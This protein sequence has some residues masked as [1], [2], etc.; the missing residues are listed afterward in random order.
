MQRGMESER[1]RMEKARIKAEQLAKTEKEV[2]NFKVDS[3]QNTSNDI[4][5]LIALG[6]HE[7]AQKMAQEVIAR[8][9]KD[10]A[11]YTWWGISLVKTKKL[12]E[13]I[14]KFEESAK[15][16]KYNPKTFLYW[17]LTLSME[18]KYE[19]A[20]QKYLHVIKLDPEN[21]NAFAYWGASLLALGHTKD[22]VER[23]KQALNVNPNNEIALDVMV[24]SYYVLSQYKEAWKVVANAR[25]RNVKIPDATLE[26]LKDAMPE[27]TS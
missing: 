1:K 3:F 8:N 17:G 16:D 14:Q 4:K 24:N 7:E 18:H 11:T 10:A 27:P 13:A 22:A 2:K 19:D 12:F 5:E 15:I 20:V 21:S 6:K 25:E 9:P 26:K 23:L